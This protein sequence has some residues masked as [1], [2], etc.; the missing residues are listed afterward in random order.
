MER[1]RTLQHTSATILK[2]WRNLPNTDPRSISQHG[3]RVG[4]VF[5]IETFSMGLLMPLLV[6]IFFCPLIRH[7]SMALTVREKGTCHHG[8][9][10]PVW[11]N[12]SFLCKLE[13]SVVMTRLKTDIPLEKR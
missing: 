1:H 10:W 3:S 12:H 13:G 8:R 5:G 4:G 9:Y 2:N 6:P 11:L 7:M